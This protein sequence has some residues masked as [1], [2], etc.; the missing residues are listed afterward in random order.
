MMYIL[1]RSFYLQASWAQNTAYKALG[2]FL[3]PVTKLKIN[4]SPEIT[5]PDLIALYHPCQLETRFG[6]QAATPTNFWPPFVGQTFIPAE[7]VEAEKRNY[8][9][10][11][12]TMLLENPLLERHPDY[13]NAQHPESRDFRARPIVEV[14]NEFKEPEQVLLIAKEE[15]SKSGP[16]V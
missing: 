14:I 8:T 6:G 5:H 11:Y 9:D 7:S 2:P 12:E 15:P 16:V 10:D 3:D 1:N 13:L 4:L